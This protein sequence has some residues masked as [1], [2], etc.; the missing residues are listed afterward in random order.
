MTVDRLPGPLRLIG[1]SPDRVTSMAGDEAR[2]TC[3]VTHR[4]TRIFYVCSWCDIPYAYRD[5][6]WT[7]QD[8]KTKHGMCC[9]CQ[10]AELRALN[11]PRHEVLR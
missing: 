9:E 4:R 7:G 1:G 10:L 3:K 2:C 8:V 11:A 5:S 6:E